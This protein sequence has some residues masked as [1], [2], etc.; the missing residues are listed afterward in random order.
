MMAHYD[1]VRNIYSSNSEVKVDLLPLLMTEVHIRGQI[2]FPVR[3][4]NT[5]CK[6]YSK[7]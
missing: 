5:G 1:T 3:N 7:L 2:Q 4:L 6:R